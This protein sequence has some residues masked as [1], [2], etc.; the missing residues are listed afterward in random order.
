MIFSNLILIFDLDDT[1][2]NELDFVQSG[3]QAVAYFLEE[4]YGVAKSESLAIMN[5]ILHKEGRGAIFDLL[6]E[7]KH[8]HCKTLVRKCVYIYRHHSPS[9]SPFPEA[10]E[11]LKSLDNPLYIVTDGHK[12]V[13]E[14]KINAL[15]IQKYF[16]KIYLTHRYGIRHSKPSIYCFDKIRKTEKCDW[17]DMVYIGDD[18]NKDF[19]N[20]KPL[21]MHTIRVLKGN[22]KDV[23]LDEIHEADYRIPDLTHVKEILR[24]LL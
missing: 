4:E 19:V 24:E 6:L 15:N 22:Y 12:I 7:M 5:N 11:L 14:K 1:L 9:I 3:F 13:Q 18:P 20:L 8:L 21:G 17:S 16:K 10:E 2:Y 23:I